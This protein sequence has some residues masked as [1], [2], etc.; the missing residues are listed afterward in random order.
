MSWI[1]DTLRD[2]A[3]RRSALAAPAA[4]ENAPQPT[5]PVGGMTGGGLGAAR[6]SPGM[7][8]EQT[9]PQARTL[10]LVEGFQKYLKR[11]GRT[12]DPLLEALRVRDMPGG[13]HVDEQTPAKLLGEP[14]QTMRVNET[15]N[16]RAG[17]SFQ[18]FELPGGR[19]VNVYYGSNGERTVVRLPRRRS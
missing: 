13:R 5:G 11:S 2:L 15:D 17:L 8:S 10:G 19:R 1:E 18:Q 6:L 16:K 3:R 4:G 7:G 9:D 14:G 12:Q